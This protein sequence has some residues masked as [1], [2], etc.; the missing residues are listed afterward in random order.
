MPFDPNDL[1]A[2]FSQ[3]SFAFNLRG[4]KA[5]ADE[6]FAPTA[7]NAAILAERRRWLAE[8]PGRYLPYTPQAADL[9]REAVELARS[10]DPAGCF[11]PAFV[12]PEG[13]NPAQTLQQLGETWEADFILCR[14]GSDG[15]FRM[16]GGAL[17]FPSNWVPETKL[18]LPVAALH[19]PV[20][21]LNAAIGA[22]IDKLLARLP[23][24]DAWLRVNWGLSASGERNQHPARRLTRLGPGTPPEATWFRVE[25]QALVRLP[26]T[27]G[28]LFGIRPYSWRLPALR[29]KAEAARAVAGQ[30]RSMP[31]EMRVYKGIQHV[32][33]GAAEYMAGP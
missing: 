6:F 13:A 12:P 8:D 7:E 17:C 3:E 15:L 16:A 25:Y 5:P 9:V 1:L 26:A 18:D 28:I 19:D 32:A 10:F 22:Q 2:R 21:G 31:E 11:N 30:I 20:P 14:R 23:A 24:G 27:G 33:E 4:W 29:E